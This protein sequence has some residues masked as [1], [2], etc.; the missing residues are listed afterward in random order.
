MHESVTFSSN[1]SANELAELASSI[2]PEEYTYIGEKGIEG[3][4]TF[5]VK[6][7]KS[8]FHGN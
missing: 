7:R 8:L 3:I 2:F 4:D 6:K 5:E 1:L